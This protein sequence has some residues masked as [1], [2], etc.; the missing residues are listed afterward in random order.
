MIYH[1]LKNRPKI[2]NR[3]AA[4]AAILLLLSSLAVP[5]LDPTNKLSGMQVENMLTEG[6]SL[7]EESIAELVGV[8]PPARAPKSFNI[9]SLI[10]RF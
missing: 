5:T 2:P 10:F 1:R 8:S 7:A 4:L 6:D 3:V 9:S